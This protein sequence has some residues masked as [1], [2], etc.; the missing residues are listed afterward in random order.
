M[1]VKLGIKAIYS[2]MGAGLYGLN[3]VGPRAS[4]H[5]IIICITLMLT[6]SLEA[7]ILQDPDYEIIERYCRFLLK[8]SNHLSENTATL[9]VYLLVGCILIEGQIHIKMLAFF[10][11]IVR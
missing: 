6:Y 5:I 4:S 2:L 11:N 3:G 7:L 10:R 9:E 8:L 1:R